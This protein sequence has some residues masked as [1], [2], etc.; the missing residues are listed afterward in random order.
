MPSSPGQRNRSWVAGSWWR[1]SMLTL[2][3]V[4]TAVGAVHHHR[5][6]SSIF[7]AVLCLAFA[8]QMWWIWQRARSSRPRS[9]FRDLDD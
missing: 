6:A 2:L 9:P 4:A 8:A 3:A 5:D 1:P 7:A